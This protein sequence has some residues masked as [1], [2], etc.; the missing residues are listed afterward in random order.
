MTPIQQQPA[1]E[2]KNLSSFLHDMMR[3]KGMS[4]E[5]LAQATGIS[6]R[7]IRLLLEERFDKLPAAPYVHGYLIKIASALNIDGEELWSEYLKYNDSLNRSGEKDI[8]PENRFV[9]INVNKK[10]IFFGALIFIIVLYIAFRI[11]SFL[12]GPNLIVFFDNNAVVTEPSFTITGNSDP[13]NELTMNG[14]V[15]YSN[16]DGGFQKIVELSPGFNT[17]VFKTKTLIGK[18]ETVVRQVYL[19]F[20]TSTGTINV[21]PIS[22]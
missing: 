21:Q 22:N 11:P 7:Y 13:K 19:K 4:I 5:K 18:E 3:I 10:I 14:E 20:T 16:K 1:G 15:L 6:E 8:L 17:F 9:G 2:I 12:G